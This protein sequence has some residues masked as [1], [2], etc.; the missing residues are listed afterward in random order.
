[1]ISFEIFQPVEVERLKQIGDQLVILFE[2]VEQSL[3]E[4][5]LLF[6]K[7]DT[8]ASLTAVGGGEFATKAGEAEGAG[9][10]GV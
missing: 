10:F 5:H 8:Y 7:S 2:K 1:M 4:E 3:G 6:M 9:E